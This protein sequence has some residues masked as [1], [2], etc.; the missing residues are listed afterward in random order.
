[1]NQN[2][3]IIESEST[4][5]GVGKSPMTGETLIVIEDNVTKTWISLSAEQVEKLKY[6][7]SH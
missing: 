2:F 4:K 6:Y 5:I 1:M 7:L 3:K